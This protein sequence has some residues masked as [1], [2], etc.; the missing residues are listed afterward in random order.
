V[1][2]TSR[3]GLG[4][5]RR[6]FEEFEACDLQLRCYSFLPFFTLRACHRLHRLTVLRPLLA[7]TSNIPLALKKSIHQGHRDI[8]P[9]ATMI[10]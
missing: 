1:S 4:K 10:C 2:G 8:F 5:A 9:H 7:D 3:A 6:R